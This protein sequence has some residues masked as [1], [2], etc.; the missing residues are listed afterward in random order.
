MIYSSGGGNSTGIKL[1]EKVGK[2]FRFLERPQSKDKKS[3]FGGV[4][5]LSKFFLTSFKVSS[6]DFVRV[7]DCSIF[8]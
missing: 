3:N 7:T 2:R 1:R 6:G 5:K 4:F 8:C